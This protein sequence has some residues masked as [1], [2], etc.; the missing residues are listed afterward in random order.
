MEG[1][2]IYGAARDITSM[3]AGARRSTGFCN[4]RLPPIGAPQCFS[5][6]IGTILGGFARESAE[7]KAA[8][9]R[10]RRPRGLLD[11]LLHGRGRLGKKLLDSRDAIEPAVDA[12]R[13]LVV[14]AARRRPACRLWR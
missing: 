4:P 13:V 8:P 14:T 10:A 11:R 2:C 9:C 7:R 5:N 1:E 6:R 12:R 3:D